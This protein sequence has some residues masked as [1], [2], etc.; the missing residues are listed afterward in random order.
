MQLNM[1]QEIN[2]SIFE[3]YIS[4]YNLGRVCD[5]DIYLACVPMK[6][7]APNIF[8]SSKYWTR[9]VFFFFFLYFFCF[10]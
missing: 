8:G 10:F 3:I 1:Y 2:N 5:V 7:K 6:T 4:S 9:D